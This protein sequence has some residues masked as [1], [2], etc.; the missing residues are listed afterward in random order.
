ME[1]VKNVL[2]KG[3]DKTPPFDLLI[4]DLEI[5]LEKMFKPIPQDEVIPTRRR[6]F[7]T[8]TRGIDNTEIATQDYLQL[9]DQLS[10]EDSF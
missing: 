4:E 10:N 3:V 7:Y 1:I 9:L 2:I 8:R 5:H 6:R